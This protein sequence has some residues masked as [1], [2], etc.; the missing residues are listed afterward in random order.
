MLLEAREV[1][2]AG[3]V[4]HDADGVRYSFKKSIKSG[5]STKIR[6][7]LDEYIEKNLDEER[8]T[9]PMDLLFSPTQNTMSWLSTLIQRSR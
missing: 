8:E 2:P 4:L 9:N 6:I 1:L 7:H 5:D 3:D